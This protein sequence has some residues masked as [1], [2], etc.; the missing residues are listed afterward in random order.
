MLSQLP[1]VMVNVRHFREFSLKHLLISLIILLVLVPNAFSFTVHLRQA[2]TDQDTF[3]AY[4]GQPLDVEIYVDTEGEPLAG[5]SVYL[6]FD[7][8]LFE[9]I[10]AEAGRD[11]IQPV[12]AGPLVTWQTL[13]N[14]THGDPGNNIPGFQ[15]DYSKMTLSAEGAVIGSG[16]VGIVHLVPI[17]PALSTKITFDDTRFFNRE[18]Q[19]SRVDGTLF[20][21]IRFRELVP[22]TISIKGGPQFDRPLPEVELLLGETVEVPLDDYV[23]DAN[24]PD[25]ALTWLVKGFQ[26]MDVKLDPVSHVLTIHSID[27]WT[28][29][30]IL[31]L[32]VSDPEGNR[33]S[34]TI[35]V[36]VR[37]APVLKPF[38][39]IRLRSGGSVKRLSLDEYVDDLDTE[40]AQMVWSMI[41]S[42]HIDANMSEQ[43]IL[44]LRPPDDWFGQETIL[45][46]VTD[47]EGHSAQGEM[48]VYVIPDKTHPIITGIPDVIASAGGSVSSPPIIDLDDFAYDPDDPLETLTWSATTQ[49]PIQIIIDPQTHRVTFRSDGWTG[50]TEV[51]FTA[52]DPQGE[53]GEGAASVTIVPENM[54]PILKPFPEIRL[55]AH[56]PGKVLNLDDFVFD[57]NHTPAQMAWNAT[58]QNLIVITSG[59]KNILTFSAEQSAQEIITL[60]VTDPD[61]NETRADLT[62]VAEGLQPPVIAAF[63]EIVL[64]AG[65]TKAVFDLDDYTSDDFTSSEDLRWRVTGFNPEHLTLSIGTDHTVLAVAADRWYGTE[66]VD[67]VATDSDGNETSRKAVFRI[68]ASP[69]LELPPRY[70]VLTGTTDTSLMLNDYVTDPDTPSDQLRWD[71]RSESELVVGLQ[72]N[73]HGLMLYAP[74]NVLGE[75][76]VQVEVQDAEGNVGIGDLLVVVVE[77]ITVVDPSPPD[78][79][80]SLDALPEITM[81]AGAMD[82]SLDL[83]NYVRDADTPPSELIWEITSLDDLVAI[84]DPDSHRLILKASRALTGAKQLQIRV[85]DPEG[86]SAS[87]S[88]LVHIEADAQSSPTESTDKT[89]PSFELFVLSHPILS[90]Q[91]QIVLMANE[92]LKADPMMTVVLSDRE[93]AVTLKPSKSLQWI[94]I[95]SAP[96][97]VIGEATIRVTGVDLSGNIGSDES[98]HFMVEADAHPPTFVKFSGYPNPATTETTLVCQTDAELSVETLIF[99]VMGQPVAT[100]SPDRFQPPQEGYVAQWNLTDDSGQRLSPGVY[101]ASLQAT[102]HDLRSYRRSWRILIQPQ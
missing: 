27:N 13:E 29:S 97:D 61:G 26:H 84:I 79:V 10:D 42:S 101:I 9:L 100:L 88:L 57:L 65:E 15:I 68:T 23:T 34:G 49:E 52:M 16:V 89:P 30:E 82:A 35:G 14:D 11:G 7:D 50:T 21:P 90:G 99:N 80:P 102:Y 66:N 76:T 81:L 32:D 48:T 75:F 83:D 5:I 53:T 62:V 41:G 37:A 94:G 63:P 67:F 25:G 12:E 60:T 6:S 72:T 56:A 47:P 45:L 92:P 58:G 17:K 28:G 70:E 71:V 40:P 78:P 93:Y 38:P 74:E 19:G 36:H 46:G 39:D 95:Y 59:P 20:R 54:P 55:V 24:T 87:Q 44:T 31:E 96:S 85:V 18:T 8:A 4:V 73:R 64:K 91:F 69:L 2:G 1:C 22:A 3:D 51:L 86:N 33:T 43:R 77:E 98:K